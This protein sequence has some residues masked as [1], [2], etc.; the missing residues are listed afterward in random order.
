MSQALGF[1]KAAMEDTGSECL[2]RKAR[3]FAVIYMADKML[4]LRLGRG[5]M[6]RDEEVPLD[7]KAMLKLVNTAPIK[8]L[9]VWLSFA[10]VQG[11]VYDKL[12]SPEALRQ[13][14]HI[15]EERAWALVRES[16]DLLNEDCHINV[17]LTVLPTEYPRTRYAVTANVS[18]DR[19]DSKGRSATPWAMSC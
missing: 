9:P 15:I 3:L 13:T 4:S 14:P 6:L 2:R 16:D 8:L 18:M 1:H 19:L 17:R 12:Y 5:S 11:L 10:R 7:A